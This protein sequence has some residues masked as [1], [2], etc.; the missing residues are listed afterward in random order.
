LIGLAGIGCRSSQESGSSLT[1]GDGSTGDAQSLQ[2]LGVLELPVLA[3]AQL[4]GKPLRVVVTT[5]IIGDVISH[6]GV[7]VIELTIL[8]QG[9]QDPHS[10]IPTAGD[11]AAVTGSHL[12]VVNGW[13][14]EEGL[15][16]DLENVGESVPI[17]PISAGITPRSYG[18]SGRFVKSGPDP[19]VW[20]N[21]NLVRQ[22]VENAKEMLTTLDPTNATLFEDNAVIYMQELDRLIAYFDRQ[23]ALIPPEKRTLVTNHD[24]FG[25][26]AEA[27]GFQIIGTILPGASTLSEPSARALVTL[28]DKMTAEKLCTI[29]VENSANDRLAKTAA[30]ELSHCDDVQ[31]VTLYSGSL[32]PFAGDMSFSGDGYL[33]MMKANVDAIVAGLK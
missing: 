4:D 18:E 20:L 10:Y 15:V 1:G 31:L 22:W 25:Y 9:G 16:R 3:P 2:A 5:G 30:A 29:F 32:G 11:L 26:F 23:V 12:I 13:D 17:A 8:M 6:I 33:A 14:L 24:S 19:H 7:D 27:Y 28:V 21:P